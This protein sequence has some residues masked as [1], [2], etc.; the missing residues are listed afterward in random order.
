MQI[1]VAVYLISANY[2]IM[3]KDEHVYGK[4]LYLIFSNWPLQIETQKCYILWCTAIINEIYTIIAKL[5]G[6]S[7]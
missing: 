4:F 3:D 1:Q 2:W 6:T 5:M 7:V